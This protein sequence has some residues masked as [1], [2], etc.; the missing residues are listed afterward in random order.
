MEFCH[1][2]HVQKLAFFGSVLRQDFRKESDVDVLI[3]FQPA[4]R[5]GFI[6]FSCM[7]R[8][9]SEIFK[10]PVDLVPLDGLKPV[11]RDSVLSNI[12]VVYAT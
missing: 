5:I 7:Q 10:R 9:L 2:Y 1:R 11:I 6:T 3:S 12:E 4:A 8:E